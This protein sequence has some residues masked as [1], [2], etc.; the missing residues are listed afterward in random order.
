MLAAISWVVLS[1]AQESTDRAF[2][3]PYTRV[4][5]AR[6]EPA[7]G[8]LQILI[9]GEDQLGKYCSETSE[10]TWLK[11]YY[12]NI[13]AT[14][15]YLVI[16]TLWLALATIV[17][18]F[19]TIRL[20]IV[21][22]CAGRRQSRETKILQRAY[23]NAEPR[24]VSSFLAPDDTSPGDRVVGHVGFRN[25]GRLPARNVQWFLDME[26]CADGERSEFNTG[27]LTGRGNIVG[28]GTMMTQGSPN[29]PGETAC[30]YYYV[31]GKVVYDDGF[32]VE[33]HTTFCHRYNTRRWLL[34]KKRDENRIRPRYGRQHHHGNDAT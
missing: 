11:E 28:P 10:K 20:W 15:R 4:S 2:A 29:I 26:Y 17:L 13:K 18:A 16:F 23:L 27:A 32:G 12:C 5:I 30:G 7:F 3:T 8:L 19:S 14:D 24:G 6:N 34:D 22:V 33:Q 25:V 1:V 31:W 21:S 9:P